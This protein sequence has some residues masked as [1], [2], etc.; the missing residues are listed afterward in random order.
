MMITG[1]RIS[2]T[3]ALQED[4]SNQSNFV[5]S[6]HYHQV[7]VFFVLVFVIPAKAGIQE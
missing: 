6:G 1:K 3:H 5:F 2:D 4:K 7:V